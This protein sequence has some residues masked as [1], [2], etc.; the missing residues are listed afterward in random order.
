ML[1][2]EAKLTLFNRDTNE[3]FEY[4]L[5]GIGEEPLAEE[6]LYIDCKVREVKTVKL[7]VKN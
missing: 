2:S 3:Q 5:K 4:D 7:K 6:E 1:K